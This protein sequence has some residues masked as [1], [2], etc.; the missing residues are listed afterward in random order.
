M[1]HLLIN[2]NDEKMKMM[3][4]QKLKMM[5]NPKLIIC[6]IIKSVSEI[7]RIKKDFVHVAKIS[8][9]RSYLK[10]LIF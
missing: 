5:K 4:N 6:Y 10:N 9:M 1:T 3:K 8:V 7:V 2:N